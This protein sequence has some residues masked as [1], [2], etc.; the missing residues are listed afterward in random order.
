M[1]PKC[2]Q[3]AKS[4]MLDRT[5]LPLE[6]LFANN[7]WQGS[8]A[9]HLEQQQVDHALLVQLEGILKNSEGSTGKAVYSVPE[10]RILL[11]PDKRLVLTV[12]L[13]RLD[14]S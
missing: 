9:A 12:P 10:V 11:K 3:A 7:A 14:C 6:G 4:V 1:E 2:S 13:A 8:M 5:R